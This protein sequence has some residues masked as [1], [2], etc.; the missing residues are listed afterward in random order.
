MPRVRAGI[1]QAVGLDLQPAR[2]WLATA[3]R[4]GSCAPAVPHTI[5]AICSWNMSSLLALA[6]IVFEAGVFSLFGLL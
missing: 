2:L 4:H 3:A 1:R 5:H 6:P